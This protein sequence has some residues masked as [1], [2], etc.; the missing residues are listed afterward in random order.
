[1]KVTMQV[2]GEVTGECDTV[3]AERR[4]ALDKPFA[5]SLSKGMVRRRWFDRLTTN[6]K[7]KPTTN[8]AVGYTTNGNPRSP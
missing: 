7:I 1:M 5:L 2:T 3:F 4:R 6:G 8:G